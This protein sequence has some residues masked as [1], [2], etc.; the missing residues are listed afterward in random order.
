MANDK[1]N[2]MFKRG[3]AA[4]LAAATLV[5]G[6]FYLTSDTDKLYICRYDDPKSD[7]KKLVLKP[8]NRDLRNYASI[9]ALP[10]INDAIAGDFYY[11]RA[12][13]V[14]A[15][16]LTADATS[17]TQ[18]N[19]DTNT[20]I[21]TV[22]NSTSVA[23]G[24]ATVTTSV[25]QMDKAGSNSG[26]AIS[27]SFKIKGAGD[28]AVTREDD[29]TLVIT[30]KDTTYDLTVVDGKVNL[31]GSDG[32]NDSITFTGSNGL[33]VSATGNTID[34]SGKELLDKIGNTVAGATVTAVSNAFDANGGF[35]TTVKV[36]Q[37]DKKSVAVTPTI[38][39]GT[40]AAEYKFAN[41]TATL[42]VYTKTEVDTKIDTYFK[43]A[44]AM[45]YMG[46]VGD[47]DP[48]KT[49]PTKNVECGWT[50]KVAVAGSYAGKTCK[51]GDLLIA[52]VDAATATDATWDY[53]PSGDEQTITFTNDKT[54][55]ISK[56]SDGVKT[57]GY[58]VA[59]GE[60]T[61]VSYSDAGGI[62][63]A[64]VNH[65]KIATPTT[66]GSTANVTQ[67]AKGSA[68]FT[69][70]TG[71]TGDDYGHVTGITTHKITVVDTHNDISAVA[72]T[73]K[74]DTG[75]ADITYVVSTADGTS[76]SCAL[77][78]ESDNLTVTNGT[79]DGTTASAGLKINLE[80]GSF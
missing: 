47:G 24:V 33:A 49:L 71:L 29:G 52:R 75:G 14:L 16:K 6:A 79:K 62:I 28:N 21:K 54:N 44:N 60:V 36:G 69:A 74:H 11:C 56:V 76:K 31:G 66:A 7:N 73:V 53:V 67:A 37:E 40:N 9:A 10:N 65:N 80:W 55:G 30:G 2:V 25:Q 27:G 39:L 63:T 4:N 59:A 38:K 50:Y 8:I 72:A 5:D 13:N 34:I 41:G 18:I 32:T 68:E 78:V 22:T 70:I 17:W 51:V 26:S 1:A 46:T 3:E 43:A 20:S 19:A 45:V 23:S 77:S 12:E 61:N 58:K 35:V 48:V 42:P 57:A 15:T 64:T